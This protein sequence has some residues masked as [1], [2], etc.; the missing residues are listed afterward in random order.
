M[1]AW[2]RTSKTDF[3]LRVCHSQWH[4]ILIKLLESPQIQSKFE[5]V[6]ADLRKQKNYYRA[7]IA[8]F[9]FAV[10]GRNLSFEELVDYCGQPVLEAAFRSDAAIRQIIDFVAGEIRV[11]SSVTS[12]FILKTVVDPNA[13]LEVLV[14]LAKTA[15]KLAN[16]STQSL[17]LLKSL[18]RF[19]NLQSFLPEKGK[20]GAILRFYESCKG[21][22]HCQSHPLFW[23]QYAIAC[24]TLE[25][26]VRAEKYFETAYS[27]AD[28]RSTYDSFQIDNHYA[29][30]LITRVIHS[31][32]LAE[33]MPAFRQARKI[34]FTQIQKERLHF[35]YRVASTFGQFF[36]TFAPQLK[37]E[38][39]DEI[40]RAAKH[41]VDRI[42]TL[43]ETRQ[44]NRNVEE[45]WRAM[46][47]ILNS[48]L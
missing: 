17:D 18:S 31:Q 27:F 26:F 8:I 32:E 37:D 43:P 14:S 33:A 11:R 21:L 25:E 28:K 2:P 4:A 6:L 34:I 42:E 3:L 41:I 10:L 30:F 40:K 29:R 9:V 16:V 35:A 48:K 12:Q 20:R 44:Q 7:L 13:T 24:T 19:S 22:P 46:Q 23:L 5:L 38:E 39:K 45:C 36:A 47:E 1:A 15:D